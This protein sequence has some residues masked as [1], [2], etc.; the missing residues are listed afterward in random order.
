MTASRDERE[1]VRAAA[2][3]A[4]GELGGPE[5]LEVLRACLTDL[6]SLVR[7]QAVLA[8]GRLREPESAPL[9]LPLVSD[10]TTRACA[11]RRCARSAR[12]AAR[13][14]S[15]CCCR[16]SAEP[17]KEI[18]F[19]AVE[20]LGQIRAPEAVAPLVAALREPDRNL[21]RAAAEGLGEI[22]DPRS[23]PDL[24]VALEDEHWS[25]RSA[26]ATALGRVASPKATLALIA[27]ADDP[28]DTVRRAAVLALGELRDARAA[29]RLVAALADPALQ[30]AARESL[31]R[32][33]PQVL[34]EMEQALSRGTLAADARKLL[35]D[36][37]GRF[38]DPAARRLLLAGLE[39]ESPAVRAEAAAALG[40][41]GFREALRPLVDRKASDPSPEV[42][43]AAASALRKLQP[44]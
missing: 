19:A 44:R 29:P 12:S 1:A 14:R 27:R 36:L 4:L 13:S 10:P 26:A 24:I 8:I 18:R 40:D 11:S 41:G 20:A 22:A 31:R 38:E 32:L 3:Q 9:L 34:P 21:R 28:D 7:Q 5:T 33:G 15:R 25:V 17:R 37:A 30:A 6:S 2:V 16:C 39:D 42:R 43:Q 23:A 35:V